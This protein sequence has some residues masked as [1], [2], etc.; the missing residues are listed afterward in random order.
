[1]IDGRR[2]EVRG[3][4]QGVGFRPFVW[5]L[6]HELGLKGRV[7]NG[8]A[9]VTIEAFGAPSDLDRLLD[10]LA[11]PPPAARVAAV[12]WAPI[13]AEA[14]DAFDIEHSDDAGPRRPSIPADLATCPA[15]LAEVRDST[16]RRHRYPFTNCTDCGPRFTIAQGVP[17]DRPATTM[18][19]FVMCADCQREYDDPADRRFHAQ[20]N[21]CP[22]C[23][24]QLTWL[25]PDG[26]PLPVRDP[27]AAA[28]AALRAGK[29][30]AIKGLGGFHLACDA[31]DERAVRRLRTRKRREEKPF[32]VMVPDLDAAAALAHVDAMEAALLSGPE[33][34]IVL[35]RPRDGGPLAPAVAPD[36]P[37]VGLMLPYTPLHHLLLAE[38]GRPLVMTSGNLSSEPIAHTTALALRLLGDVA[39]A[40]LVHDREITTR[41]DDSVATVLAGAPAVLRRSR[42][43]V[44]RPIPVAVPFPEPVLAVGADLKNAFCLGVDDTAWLGPHVGDLESLA[45]YEALGEAIDR[46]ERFLGVAPRVVAHD[47]HPNYLSTRFAGERDA[48]VRIGVQHHH[49]HVAAALAEH[50]LSQAIGV[51]CD[52]TGYGH[53]GAGWGAEVLVAST[54]DALRFG[55]WRPMRLAG[56]DRA[57]KEPWRVALDLVDS[58]HEAPPSVALW[59]SVEGRAVDV[60]RRQLAAGVNAPSAHG[61][62]RLFDGIAALVLRRPTAGYE[63]QLAM[64]LEQA[65]L[66]GDHGAYDAPITAGA[67]WVVDHRPL[68]RG[69][70]A[71]LA[72]GVPSGVVSARFH[73]TV[74]RA[75]AELVLGASAAHGALPVVLTGGCFQ[76]AILVGGLQEAL[77]DRCTVFVHR[78]V[79]PGDGGIALGQAVV[80]GARRA[81]REG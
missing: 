31:T 6:A 61:L 44:P 45:T 11:S 10:R 71:D 65:A 41:T 28:A 57:M 34:P 25:R 33:R 23:G 54:T 59:A 69:V 40:F 64:A 7:R 12:A 60:V 29:I 4:V 38:V 30:V 43:Y 74:V 62:G 56:G 52:G 73:A 15:C 39:D 78:E 21:A 19:G 13:P 70:V 49:A 26:A 42:G 16:D 17:Y 68:V 67:P 46:L 20:P 37:R 8:A 22:V 66:P 35:L 36:A 48:D 72:A 81:A 27:L 24:P 76:N 50:G 63:G 14:L 5:R 51:A 79:P 47:L 2:I 77:R 75:L 55:T 1:M 58:A 9:G 53:D 80:A 18:A 32:A 3:S